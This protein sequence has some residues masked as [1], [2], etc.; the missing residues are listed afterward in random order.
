MPGLKIQITKLHPDAIIPAYATPGSVGMDLYALSDYTVNSGE[1]V[2]ARTGVAIAL[3]DG[4][5]ATIRPR[6][7]NAWK[8]GVTVMNSPG[9]VD[10][11][12]RGELK[13]CLVKLSNVQIKHGP[14]ATFTQHSDGHTFAIRKGDRIAQLVITPVLRAS[15]QEVEKLD[16]TVRGEGGFG[17]TGA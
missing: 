16:E 13:V 12:Y 4:F 15:L 7:G 3:P 5:E 11:D 2:M 17:S 8:H 1:R 10:S 6:S 9:T 14:G